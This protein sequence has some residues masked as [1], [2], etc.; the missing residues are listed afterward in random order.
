MK[1]YHRI[2]WTSRIRPL[3]RLQTTATAVNLWLLHKPQSNAFEINT[4]EKE[5]NIKKDERVFRNRFELFVLVVCCFSFLCRKFNQSF[6]WYFNEREM[7]LY[8]FCF[9]YH[10]WFF[11]YLYIYIKNW[12]VKVVFLKMFEFNMQFEIHTENQFI[13]GF[14]LWLIGTLFHVS[15]TNISHMII[16]TNKNENGKKP[17]AGIEKGSG[18]AG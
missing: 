12:R 1:K 4:S 2:I 10:T 16:D 11:F 9:A 3:F 17:L 15:A 8:L 7:V 5:N 18:N 6:I 13:F 14:S